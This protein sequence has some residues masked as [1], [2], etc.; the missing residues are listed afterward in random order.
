M[1]AK[2]ASGVGFG[3]PGYGFIIMTPIVTAAH[4]QTDVGRGPGE[5]ENKGRLSEKK[6]GRHHHH[7]VGLKAVFGDLIQIL[8][9]SLRVNLLLL[10]AVW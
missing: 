1:I 7:D 2:R 10:R 3:G 5:K 6:L 4:R 8:I 9:A